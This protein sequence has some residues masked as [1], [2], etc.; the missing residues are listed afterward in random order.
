MRS[1]KQRFYS[2]YENPWRQFWETVYAHLQP[3]HSVLNAGCGAD[4]SASLREKCKEVT[5]IDLGEGVFKNPDIDVPIMGD[6]ERLTLPPGS[7]D[8][9]VCQYVVEHL[10][11]PEAC[12]RGFSTVLKERGLC[13][14]S[15][16]NLLHYGT[17]LTRLTPHCFHNW[18]ARRILGGNSEQ[19]PT[20]YR[21]NTPHR[22]V[23]MMGEAGF[24]CLDIRLI[25]A[26]PDY[27]AFSPFTYLIGVGYERL[28]NRLSCLSGLRSVIIATFQKVTGRKALE[29]ILNGTGKT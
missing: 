11:N 3:D 19:F 29:G 6:L 12:F 22:L 17:I 21:A 15:T 8:I 5:G 9:I 28:V 27:L 18:Y 2:G 13:F 14:I 24:K 23:V 7:F 10:K 1:L 20:Y 16:P 4:P 25:E 26:S